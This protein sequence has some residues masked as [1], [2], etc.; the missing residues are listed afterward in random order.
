[1]DDQ[2]VAIYCVCDD[3]LKELHHP[4]DPQRTMSDAA[5]MTTALVAACFFGGN[6]GVRLHHRH[7]S[8]CGARHHPHPASPWKP[9]WCP[10]A[11]M[12]RSKPP[13]A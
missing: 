10:V 11:S 13:A 12:A 5:V 9:S 4:E 1:M 8:H 2:V 7:L 3:L 6:R